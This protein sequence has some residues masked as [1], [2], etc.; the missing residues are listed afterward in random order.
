MT[1][2]VMIMMVNWLLSALV[3]YFPGFERMIKGDRYVLIKDGE[4][5]WH[6]LRKNYISYSELT[7]AIHE[8]GGTTDIRKVKHAFFEQDGAISIILYK[9]D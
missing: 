8:K 2:A 4:I 1:G 6:M 3:Y 9:D 5:Q 7:D